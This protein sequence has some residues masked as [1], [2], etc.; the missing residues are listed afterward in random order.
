MFSIPVLVTWLLA[1]VTLKMKAGKKPVY[2]GEYFNIKY[3]LSC[4]VISGYCFHF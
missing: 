2:C 3:S 1:S 4:G